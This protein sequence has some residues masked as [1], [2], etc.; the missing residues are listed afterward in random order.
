MREQTRDKD[1]LEHIIEAIEN[2]ESYTEDIEKDMLSTDKLRLH[3]C[4]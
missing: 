4:I 1:R 2:V 3:A